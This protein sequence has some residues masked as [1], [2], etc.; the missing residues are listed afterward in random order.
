M[1]F[2]L[3]KN[4]RWFF[5]ILS[6]LIHV[7]FFLLLIYLEFLTSSS[8]YQPGSG[9]DKQAI[10]VS[11]LAKSSAF[12]RKPKVL[13]APTKT[14]LARLAPQKKLPKTEKEKIAPQKKIAQKIEKIDQRRQ[15]KALIEKKAKKLDRK[16][17]EEREKITDKRLAAR[18]KRFKLRAK[19]RIRKSRIRLNGSQEES[20]RASQRNLI[21]TVARRRAPE[22]KLETVP[23]IKIKQTVQ[24]LEA[25]KSVLVER[26]PKT[27]ERHR[28]RKELPVV[29]SVARPLYID[30]KD[31]KKPIIIPKPQQLVRRSIEIPLVKQSDTDFDA[32]APP[33]LVSSAKRQMEFKPET[34]LTSSEKYVKTNVDEPPKE[35]D[36]SPAQFAKLDVE[37]KEKKE[38]EI[39][40]SK[41]DNRPS[42][43]KLTEKEKKYQTSKDINQHKLK[44]DENIETT[45]LE[46]KEKNMLVASSKTEHEVITTSGAS[47]DKV[48][49]KVKLKQDENYYDKLVDKDVLDWLKDD[50]NHEVNEEL[51][52]A[53]QI[54]IDSSYTREL[55]SLEH[56]P[57]KEMKEGPNTVSGPLGG[58]KGGSS[59]KAYINVNLPFSNIV[60]TPWFELTGHVVNMDANRIYLTIN[61]V[62]HVVPVVGGAFSTNL[63]FNKGVNKISLLAMSHMDNKMAK[64]NFQILYSAGHN[65]PTVTL[66][67]PIDGTQGFK[68]GDTIVVE[69]KV[70]DRTI[71]KAILFF[72]KRP[73]RLRVINGMFHKKVFMPAGRI[74]TFRVM[75]LT[76]RRAKIYSRM[77]TVLSGYD[78]DNI[79]NPRPY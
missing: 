39:S 19:K 55:D 16:I 34:P 35:T 15:D 36:K 29:K 42:L 12:F 28:E 40:L 22:K 68:E 56:A 63:D 54:P 75:A 57:I 50:E 71:R 10:K 64:R 32:N 77:H 79:M 49:E 3:E 30:K 51:I 21:T 78:S 4:K 6:G 70:E 65:L 2:G 7:L 76:R 20:Q 72:N 45:Q 18:P 11:Y 47:F 43:I 60:Q 25:E 14:K 58:R 31:S 66:T 74:A 17:T 38:R 9:F 8:Q 27:P 59:N 53:P 73:V 5:L 33:E 41:S 37:K 24:E 69:G 26:Q 44:I 48:L 13:S 52:Q 1:I 61:G 62:S 67:L 23:S 46:S